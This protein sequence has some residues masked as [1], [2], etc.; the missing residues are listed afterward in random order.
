MPMTYNI[1]KQFARLCL[2]THWKLAFIPLELFSFIS[3][4]QR[5]GVSPA[6]FT[7]VAAPSGDLLT[8]AAE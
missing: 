5:A 3:K 4:P 7:D 1:D 6:L 2:I 8:T